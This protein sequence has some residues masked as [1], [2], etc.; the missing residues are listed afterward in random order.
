MVRI[1]WTDAKT[2]RIEARKDFTLAASTVRI[3]HDEYTVL[4]DALV[5]VQAG[6]VIYFV[7]SDSFPG[8][9]YVLLYIESRSAFTCS[10]PQNFHFHRQCSHQQHAMVFVTHRYT[11]RVEVERAIGEEWALHLEDELRQAEQ[12]RRYENLVSVA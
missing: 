5:H 1:D 3:L 11:R 4:A 8:W 2:V 9:Y 7:Q 6:Q 10:C 12:E